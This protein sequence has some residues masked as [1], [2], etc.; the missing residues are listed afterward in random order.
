[1]VYTF[2]VLTLTIDRRLENPVYQ[3]VADQLRQLV[4]SG[5]I[6]AGTLLP[7]VRLLAGDLG[8]SLNT[9]AR[10]YRRLAAEG[11]IVIRHRT[12][13]E[14]APPAQRVAGSPQ[15]RLLGELRATLARFCQ[16]GMPTGELLQVVGHEIRALGPQ[17]EEKDDE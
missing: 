3:Q 7:S 13:A 10:A 11:F 9:I 17:Y 8:V 1:M 4:A 6:P 15:V 12:G 16:E 5:A 2:S 14:V